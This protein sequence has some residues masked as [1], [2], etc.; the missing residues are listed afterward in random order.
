MDQLFQP[1]SQVDAAVTRNYGGTGLGLVISK[2]LVELMDGKIWV[3]SE[4]GKGSTFYFTIK[5]ETA[6]D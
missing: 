6:P 1:F 5:A 4:L 2:K 3:E